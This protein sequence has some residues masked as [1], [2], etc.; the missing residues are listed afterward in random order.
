[1]R[2]PRGRRGRAG[3]PRAPDGQGPAGASRGRRGLRPRGRHRRDRAGRGDRAR[4]PRGRPWARDPP[5]LRPLRRRWG[6]QRELE[7][8]RRDRLPVAVGGEAVRVRHHRRSQRIL[9][10]HVSREDGQGDPAGGR[11]GDGTRDHGDAGPRVAQRY[12]PGPRQRQARA[13]ALHR[14]QGGSGGCP[15]GLRDRGLLQGRREARRGARRRGGGGQAEGRGLR[16]APGYGGGR[17]RAGRGDVRARRD[18]SGDGNLQG[19][20]SFM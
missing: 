4:A 16:G 10:L 3:G 13:A 9:D 8:R 12:G 5:A 19:R 17:G 1:D 11:G 2:H 6:A 14:W 15:E 7:P 20:G 18:V